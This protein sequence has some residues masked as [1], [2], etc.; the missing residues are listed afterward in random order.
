MQILLVEDNRD[1]AENVADFCEAVGHELVLAMDGV[2]ALRLLEGTRYD[3]IVLD[4]MLPRMDGL[5]F[6]QQAR[7]A[8]INIPVLI[9]TARD[10][11]EEKL[12]GFAAGADDYLIKPFALPELLARL[13]ALARRHTENPTSS[14]L[15]IEGLE[16][17]VENF[18]VRRD[19]VV[20]Q[21]N[22]TCFR[23][24]VALAQ[25]APKPLSR[26]AL[27]QAIWG[28]DSDD[29]DALRTHL[30]HLRKVVDKPFASELIQTIRGVGLRL[31]SGI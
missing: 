15:C 19:G 3:V 8:G 18:S 4:L 20:L 28:G 21:L 14:K 27:S 16:I 11:L 7:S 26:K 5:T 10:T 24:L 6:L 17:D 12:A 23:L 30:Y 22:Q 29:G 1:I 9:V 31:G 2:T 25:A 13:E